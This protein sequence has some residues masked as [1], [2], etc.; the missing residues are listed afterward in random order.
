MSL[1]GFVNG[2]HDSFV[3]AECNG[4]CKQQDGQVGQDTD[5]GET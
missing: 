5:Y 1:I 2:C 4:T 3:D